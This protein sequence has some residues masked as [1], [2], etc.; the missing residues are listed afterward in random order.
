M[1]MSG[2]ECI[3]PM[4]LLFPLSW[5]LYSPRQNTAVLSKKMMVLPL[6]KGLL[7]LLMVRDPPSSHHINHPCMHAFD[8]L[9]FL[10][11]DSCVRYGMVWGVW[12]AML[13]PTCHLPALPPPPLSLSKALEFD[14]LA[15]N[16][17]QRTSHGNLHYEWEVE[18]NVSLHLSLSLSLSLPPSLPPRT[19][20]R[21]RTL[22]HFVPFL[23]TLI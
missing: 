13:L 16:G 1:I 5:P 23:F 22:P 11:A 21:T 8:S 7:L 10:S 12:C 3:E 4:A 6:V 2:V 18:R 19:R 20:T 14:D 17:T 9:S 15:L